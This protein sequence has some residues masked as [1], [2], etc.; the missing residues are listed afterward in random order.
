MTQQTETSVRKTVTVAASQE[1]A[2]EV[3]TAGFGTWWPM[4]HHIG[5]TEPASVT[6]EPGAGGRWF[7]T[8]VDGVDCDWGAVLVWEPPHRV[9]TSWHLQGDWKYDPD[10]AKASEVEVRF[11]AEGPNRTRVELEHR[12]FERHGDGAASVRGGVGNPE[13]GWG[14]IMDLYA[15]R[16][17]QG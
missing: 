15:A 7:E 3:F 6:L 16:V 12:H 5:A 11:V 1:R 17:Q 13:G 10:P 2:F 9:V 8:G 14:H 4:R